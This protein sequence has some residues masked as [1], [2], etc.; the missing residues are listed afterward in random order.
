MRSP[1]GR[2]RSLGVASVRSGRLDPLRS[3]PSSVPSILP[4]RSRSRL[5][6]VCSE[7]RLL[8]HR[9]SERPSRRVEPS[10]RR[11]HLTGSDRPLS[12]SH[13]ESSVF[14][15]GCSEAI[16]LGYA[17]GPTV[18]KSNATPGFSACFMRTAWLGHA[19]H[20][21]SQSR[22]PVRGFAGVRPGEQPSRAWP[23]CIPATL[24]WASDQE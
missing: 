7:G 19:E 17:E 14:R 3:V 9:C 22:G 11:C 12:Q 6:R 21:L 2:K 1:Y 18:T 15:P 23:Q 20:S 16:W 24:A 4:K 13:G 8:F 10:R 5:F